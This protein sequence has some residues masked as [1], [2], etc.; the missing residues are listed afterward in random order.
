MVVP[1]PPWWIDVGDP[2]PTSPSL[3]LCWSC[4]CCC[5]CAAEARVWLRV[6]RADKSGRGVCDAGVG[7]GAG[8]GR[9]AEYEPE[10]EE[11]VDMEEAPG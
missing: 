7:A 8:G 1:Q 11:E 3:P 4:C 6:C 5:C 9:K 2:A 10:V